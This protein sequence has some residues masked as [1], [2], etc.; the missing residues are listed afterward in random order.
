[1]PWTYREITSG[2]V[3]EVI[4][5]MLNTLN[6]LTPDQALTVKTTASN[7]Y[8]GDARG[9]IVWH[10]NPGFVGPPT[11]RMPVWIRRTATTDHD[12]TQMYETLVTSLNF[13]EFRQAYYVGISMTNLRHGTATLS[14]FFREVDHGS[15]IPINPIGD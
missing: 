13:M 7:Q 2:D 8:H 12:Y 4:A 11:F 1:M 14:W 3:N 9:L 5:G 15:P 6:T 10:T